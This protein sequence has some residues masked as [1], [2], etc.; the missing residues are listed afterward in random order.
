MSDL[1]YNY[2]SNDSLLMPVTHILS[3]KSEL[4]LIGVSFIVE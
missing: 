1:G 2:C 4:E 3:L